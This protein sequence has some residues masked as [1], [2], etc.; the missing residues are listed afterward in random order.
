[1]DDAKIRVWQIPKGGLKETLTE[2]ECVLRGHTE[3]IYSIKFHPHA[4]G[5]LVSSSY[6]LTVRLWNLEKGEE[7]KK[8]SGHQDQ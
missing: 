6:D 2:P 4:S 3:K 5:L 1:G 8:L 7:V